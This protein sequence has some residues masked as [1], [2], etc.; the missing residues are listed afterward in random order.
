VSDRIALTGLRVRGRH[1]VFEHER[2]DGQEFV[3]DAVLEVSTS[4]AAASDELKDTVDYGDL[5]QRLAAVVSGE[6]VNLLESLAA[7]LVDVCLADARVDAA[8]VTVHKPQAP[9]P[10]AFSDVAVTIRRARP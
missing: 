8:T 7:R 1:G 10:L 2:R 5:A 9:I 4:M 3:V 6:P